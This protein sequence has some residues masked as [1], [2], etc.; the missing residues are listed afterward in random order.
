MQVEAV[1]ALWRGKPLADHDCAAPSGL[2]SLLQCTQLALGMPWW[3]THS[4]WTDWSCQEVHF[5]APDPHE[6]RALTFGAASLPALVSLPLEYA[7]LHE[8][9]RGLFS[10]LP[11]AP[12]PPGCAINLLPSGSLPDWRLYS[13]AEG[14]W[15]GG[16]ERPLIPK[17]ARGLHLTFC[18][19]NEGS[20]AFS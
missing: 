7:D 3:E 18:F 8:K 13:L 12:P 6:S 15:E 11:S 17:S 20:M 9:K 10:C 16:T 5:Q 1:D 14:R 2:H 19:P 4:P